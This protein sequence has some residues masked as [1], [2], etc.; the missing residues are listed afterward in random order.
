M[1]FILRL[2]RTIQYTNIIILFRTQTL[3]RIFAIIMTDVSNGYNNML[4][5]QVTVILSYDTV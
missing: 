3:Y 5:R 4:V 2:C 1:T